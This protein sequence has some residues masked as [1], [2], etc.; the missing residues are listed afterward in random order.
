MTWDRQWVTSCCIEDG[1]QGC[2]AK[3]HSWFN[4]EGVQL[5]VREHISSSGEKLTAWRIAKAVGE[6]LKSNRARDSAA[7]I[8]GRKSHSSL[9]NWLRYLLISECDLEL[10]KTG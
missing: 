6:Y 7:E 3:S 2:H 10:H 9:M 1:N 4:D 8:L 5:S